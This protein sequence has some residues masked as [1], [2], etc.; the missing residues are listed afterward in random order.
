MKRP[1]NIA[2]CGAG[3][4]GLSAAHALSG[5]GHQITL[6]DPAGLKPD[7]ASAMAG[8]MLAPYAEIEHMPH[9]WITAGLA[10][11]TFWKTFAQSHDI[12]F[13][14][15]GSLLIAH[16]EDRYILERFKTHLPG[17][18]G[19]ETETH[20]IEPALTHRFPQGLHLKDEAHLNPHKTLHA[21]QKNIESIV[22]QPG[23][24]NKLSQIYD[25]VIDCRG[26][27]AEDEDLRGVKGEI[28][29]VRN[30]EFH[31]SRPVRLMHPRYPLYIVPRGEGI[32]MIGATVIE[33]ADETVTL[34]SAM[35]LMSALYSLSPSFGEAEILG[36]HAGV[37]PTYPDNLPRIRQEG[38]VIRCNGL[39][40][41]GYLLAPVMAQC[42]A[43]ELAEK[44]NSFAH[45]FKG[46][47]N[48]RDHQRQ[49]TK[50]RSAA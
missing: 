45:L 27:G 48:D 31:L 19:D 44:D 33:S 16:D 20:E 50:L 24:P 22:S 21:L 18:A 17:A 36:I 5:A 2:I 47:H 34:R 8:G 37:R 28:V 49:K 9:E 41:H 4:M 40:R 7:N 43:D 12:G 25:Y 10:G 29:I 15:S 26:M 46:G 6:Y 23:Y 30:P 14:R 38:N 1:Q 13:S 35:E 32:F 42:V 11:I 3:I 39:F